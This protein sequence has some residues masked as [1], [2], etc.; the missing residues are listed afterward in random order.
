VASVERRGDTYWVR[1]APNRKH[2][3][4][5]KRDGPYLDRESAQAVLDARAPA[6]V[7]GAI[8]CHLI[9]QREIGYHGRENHIDR[10]LI[11]ARRWTALIGHIPLGD[12]KV[13][14]VEGAFRTL[15]TRPEPKKP[16]SRKTVG[17][18]RSFLIAALQNYVDELG[19]VNIARASQLP[20][21][22][23]IKPV[24]KGVFT[25]VEVKKL[26][27]WAFEP[28]SLNEK[29]RLPLLVIVAT[30]CR[31]GEALGLRKSDLQP[32]GKVVIAQQ[33]KEVRGEN[34]GKRT[35]EERGLKTGEESSRQVSIPTWLW[36]ELSELANGKDNLDLLF[37][38]TR[39]DTFNQWLVRVALRETGIPKGN[40]SL[41]SLRHSLA[42][43]LLEAG[44]TPI[45]VAGQLGH[46]NVSTTLRSYTHVRKTGVAVAAIELAMGNHT[47]V[48]PAPTRGKAA[49]GRRV[50]RSRRQ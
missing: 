17:N 37:G 24:E 44:H 27:E 7:A 48:T 42:Q 39:P 15:L 4:P 21:N 1:T 16:L 11:H 2:G 20:K 28:N 43:S 8:A 25:P 30:G 35:A 34:G 38:V 6:T 40:R 12:L 19:G 26:V 13:R 9:E 36:S 31:R 50:V 32:D 33:L 46:A 45:S 23:G 18:H 14:D 47:P 10:G 29:W 49:A 5:T 3:T 41:H 22:V